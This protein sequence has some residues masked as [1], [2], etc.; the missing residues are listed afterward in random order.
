MTNFL[1]QSETLESV[2]D[3]IR[4][5]ATL[6]QRAELSFG[7]GTDNAF[8]EAKLLVFHTLALPWDL[9][10][11]YYHA[12]LTLQEKQQVTDLFR[13]RIESREPSAYLIGEANFAGLR[14]YVNESVLVPR[15]PIAELIA[16]RY[17]PWVDPDQ[18]TRILDLCTGSG[19]IGIASLQACPQAEVDLADISPEALAVARRNV[20]RY[21]LEDVVSVIESDLFSALA[22]RQYDLIVSNPPYV[23]AIEMAHLPPEFQQ[24]PTLGLAAGEDG[25]DLA[26]RILA[27]A[28]QHLTEDGTLIVEVGV[29]QY[30]LQ[31]A[32]PELPFYWFE[33]EQG[34]EGVFALQKSEL[35]AF[36]AVLQ[37]RKAPGCY[38]DV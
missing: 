4:W 38:P 24:E 16:E 35:D 19:C 36:E 21:Q 3:F 8:A 7:H 28:S 32:Y 1:Y 37:A 23:D 17:Q 27:E 13:H 5:G 22:G 2:N 33:F 6:F 25:L 26:R 9:P 30:Y 15:S 18:V 29:S 34:G 31:Q 20:A 10:E 11:A 14:F 12:R